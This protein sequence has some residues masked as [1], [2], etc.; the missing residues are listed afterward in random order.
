MNIDVVI[1]RRVRE[2]RKGRGY[3]L[4]TLAELSGVSRS[5]IS[6]IERSETSPTAAV[7]NKIADALDVTLASLFSDEPG[8][9][10]T[11][12]SRVAEQRIWKDPASGYV[13]RHVSPSGYPSPI[14]L[15]EVLF[16][17]G[18]T[19]TFENIV[20]SIM[21]HQQVWVLQGEMIVTVGDEISHL[22]AGD[23]L[24]MILGPRIIF[25]NPTKKPAKYAVAL[26]TN[27]G[28]SRRQG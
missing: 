12:L 9:A 26:T 18:E 19:V 17:A 24:A 11:P 22:H 28:N 23:C 16:P 10:P 20:R 8:S 25:R 6:L 1:A 3:A 27:T 14:E 2:L 21:T 15:V 7:L 4:D 13:R 5:M